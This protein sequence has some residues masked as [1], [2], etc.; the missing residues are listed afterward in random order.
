MRYIRTVVVK[1]IDDPLPLDDENI[2]FHIIWSWVG[3]D[4]K[5]VIIDVKYIV[6]LISALQHA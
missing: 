1:K 3:R 6:P 4:R 5:R 2:L